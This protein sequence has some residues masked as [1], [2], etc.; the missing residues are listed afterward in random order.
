MRSATTL[1]TAA[2]QSTTSFA[3]ASDV[4]LYSR[5]VSSLPPSPVRPNYPH[6]GA[7]PD[8]VALD[9]LRRPVSGVP[10]RADPVR[11][12]SG[13]VN[14]AYAD[15]RRFTPPS[16]ARASYTPREMMHFTAINSAMLVSSAAPKVCR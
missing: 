4:V 14:P 11:T 13:H 5:A 8:A 12:D 6:C 9:N 7:A 3:N 2:R 16:T 10:G 1:S 15:G